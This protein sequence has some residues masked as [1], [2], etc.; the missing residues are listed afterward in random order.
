MPRKD[1]TGQ[2][3]G[4]F[5]VLEFVRQDVTA[6]SARYMC[7]CNLCG[8]V[9]EK[10]VNNI[11]SDKSC[12]CL[13]KQNA[14]KH[15]FYV[16]GEQHPLCRVWGNMKTRCNNPHDKAY[17]N[18]GGRGIKVCERWLDS[19]PNFLEDM[20][21]RPEGYSIDRI[22]ND[23]NYEPSNCRWANQTTQCNNKQRNRLLT[24]NNETHTIC[25]WSR[26]VNI[27]RTTIRMRL[28]SY[29]W[30]LERALTTPVQTFIKQGVN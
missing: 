15:G 23:G 21:E 1:Y 14:L 13:P 19:F 12:G 25:Q 11:K 30:D 27:G 22:N 24:F 16:E 3:I 8:S 5:T 2:T 7:K 28:D 18:Y 20:G 6:H 4:V 29:G 9:K 17:K 10:L 26:L